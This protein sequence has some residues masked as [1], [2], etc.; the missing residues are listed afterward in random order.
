LTPYSQNITFGMSF[1]KRFKIWLRDSIVYRAFIKATIKQIKIATYSDPHGSAYSKAKKAPS[2]L[3]YKSILN[4]AQ[5]SMMHDHLRPRVHATTDA[6]QKMGISKIIQMI[7]MT[8][9]NI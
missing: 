6:H 7:W 2:F 5:A 8:S 1:S 4:K 3:S 9:K